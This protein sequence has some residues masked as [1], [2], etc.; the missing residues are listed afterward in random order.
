M[1]R[2]HNDESTH[3]LPHPDSRL[4]FERARQSIPIVPSYPHPDYR[5]SDGSIDRDRKKSLLYRAFQLSPRDKK[6]L[7]LDGIGRPVAASVI[8][9]RCCPGKDRFFT[10]CL[11]GQSYETHLSTQ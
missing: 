8:K 6:I 2:C 3:N 11:N 10:R 7:A 4:A 1:H 9:V 5:A